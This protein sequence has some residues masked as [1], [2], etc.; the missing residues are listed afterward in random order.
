VVV[1]PEV[2]EALAALND[3]SFLQ[4]RRERGRT[5]QLLSG[6]DDDLTFATRNHAKG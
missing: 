5:L 3:K 2:L 1:V 4:K 6:P